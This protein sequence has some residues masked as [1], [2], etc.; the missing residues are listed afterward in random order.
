M[1]GFD[2]SRRLE[3]FRKLINDYEQ[4]E[5]AKS[6]AFLRLKHTII[7]N[8]N[9]LLVNH[10]FCRYNN[11]FLF[12]ILMIIYGLDQKKRNLRNLIYDYERAE[13]ASRNCFIF[14]S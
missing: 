2:Y 11:V 10:I 5:R 13:R 9:I 14:V 8:L 1:H 6:V 4:A 12:V 3:I 7:R